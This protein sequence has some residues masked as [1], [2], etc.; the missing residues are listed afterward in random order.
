MGMTA[1]D[2]EF[3]C[4]FA[5]VFQ[6]QNATHQECLDK[7]NDWF[8]D[9]HEANESYFDQ[10]DIIDEFLDHYKA[11]KEYGLMAEVQMSMKDNYDFFSARRDWDV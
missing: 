3:Q 1:K 8:V 6:L 10:K 11:I 9:F 2:L 4:A 7:I 5:E